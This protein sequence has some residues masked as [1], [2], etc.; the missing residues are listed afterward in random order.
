MKKKHT[1]K[2]SPGDTAV[3][4]P[5]SSFL[6]LAETCDILA[7]DQ[8]TEEDANAW[9]EIGDMIRYQANDNHYEVEIEEEYWV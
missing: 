8:L 1:V 6:Y 5:Y 9:R 4:M 2:M 7:A 3:V